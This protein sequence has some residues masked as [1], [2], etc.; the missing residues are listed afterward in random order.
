[1]KDPVP[2]SL[3][4]RKRRRTREAIVDAAFALFAERGFAA[5]SVTDIAESADVG[6]STFFRYFADKQEVVFADDPELLESL[7]SA[8]EQAAAPLA[9]LGDSLTAALTAARAGVM[10]V[11]RRAG[12]RSRWLAVRARL[13]E[14]Q[15]ELLARRLVKERGH[16]A[17]GAQA[18]VRHG[19][20]S[21]V[22]ALAASLAWACLGAG[23]ARAKA[24]GEG[25]A[26]A[27]DA[28]FQRLT[29]LDTAALAAGYG[30]PG[31][32]R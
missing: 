29:T 11:S 5:V 25:L 17:A 30:E 14:E 31:S 28:A 10:A 23:R 13:L 3:R 9:P 8:I 15:P 1:M 4:A 24:T 16:A 20:P 32:V 27:V 7:V 18:L 21:D 6:R 19:A 12:R 26:A 22:A 2:Q